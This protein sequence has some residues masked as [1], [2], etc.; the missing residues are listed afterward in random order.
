MATEGRGVL[1]LA[2][3]FHLLKLF[4]NHLVVRLDG[5]FR[6]EIYTIGENILERKYKNVTQRNYSLIGCSYGFISVL[7]KT[8]TSIKCKRFPASGKHTTQCR[9]QRC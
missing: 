5:K 2:L 9:Y 1:T 3:R 4:F 8:G 7:E 6:F